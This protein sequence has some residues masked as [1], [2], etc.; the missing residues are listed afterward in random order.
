MNNDYI[1]ELHIMFET[2]VEQDQLNH[3]LKCILGLANVETPPIVEQLLSLINKIVDEKHVSAEQME[4]FAS[5]MKIV[6]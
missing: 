6:E 3:G 2:Q 1:R 5:L 4:Q